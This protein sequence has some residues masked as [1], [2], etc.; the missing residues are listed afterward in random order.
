[1]VCKTTIH[2]IEYTMISI[3]FETTICTRRI[4]E[5][6][7]LPWH[8]ITCLLRRIRL[9]TDKIAHNISLRTTLYATLSS[10]EEDC[11]TS[12]NYNLD[13]MHCCFDNVKNAFVLCIPQKGHNAMVRLLKK[14][15]FPH[16]MRFRD[17]ARCRR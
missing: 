14:T 5:T 1:M 2:T 3:T 17:L 10:P 16:K 7:K 4:I 15:A 6:I 11:R 9:H 8:I 13:C 12:P